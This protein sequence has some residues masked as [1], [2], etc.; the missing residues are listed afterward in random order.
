[1]RASLAFLF[2]VYNLVPQGAKEKCILSKKATA[3]GHTRGHDA[4]SAQERERERAGRKEKKRVKESHQQFTL[5]LGHAVA[6]PRPRSKWPA[7]RSERT[8]TQST[9][10]AV[11]QPQKKKMQ[12]QQQ[13][14][15]PHRQQ[16]VRVERRGRRVKGEDAT[17]R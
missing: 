12:Q 13:Q 7:E 14:S 11:S 15:L 6:Y 8:H 10:R 16:V 1:M 2:L 4:S 17:L 9:V 5:D 3:F